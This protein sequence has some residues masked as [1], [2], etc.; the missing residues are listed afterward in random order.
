MSAADE[1]RSLGT[2]VATARNEAG[3]LMRDEIALIKADLQRD[4]KLRTIP[5]LALLTAGLLA[6]FAFLALTLGLAYWL[7]AWW[8]VPLAIAFTITGGLYLLLA[9]ALVAFAG[10]AFKTMPKA[11]VTASV[12]ESVSAVLTALKAHPD[13][14]GGAGR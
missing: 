14:S 2:L 10:R 7:H 12:K 3:A 1:G 4:A 9:G 11:D 8:G 6:L 5:M 13:G